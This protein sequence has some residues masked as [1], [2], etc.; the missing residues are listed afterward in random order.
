MNKYGKRWKKVAWQ[1]GLARRGKQ[2]RHNLAQST[3][4][5][6]LSVEQSP[7][8]DDHGILS[9]MLHSKSKQGIFEAVEMGQA[10][11]NIA[12]KRQ[13]LPNDLNREMTGALTP[14]IGKRKREENE[15]QASDRTQSRRSN[16]KRSSTVDEPVMSAPPH[17]LARRRQ[18]PLPNFNHSS[19]SSDSLLG[20]TISMQARTLA[21]N[22]RSDATHTD[23]FRLKA[24]GI[25]PDTP[26][27]PQTRKKAS[28][29]TRDNLRNTDDSQ[30]SKSKAAAE[31]VSVNGAATRIT[32]KSPK[33]KLDDPDEE[34]FASIKKVRDTLAD[35]TS[36]FQNERHS[37][38]RSQTSQ[39]VPQFGN[40]P[41]S[42]RETPA[43]RR[44]REIRER[45]YT[46]SRSEIRL[47]AMGDKAY[48]PEGFWDGEGMGRSLYGSDDGTSS[49]KEKEAESEDE[50][51]VDTD[52]EVRPAM[53]FA[54]LNK[55]HLGNGV[56]N[57]Q[58]PVSPDSPIQQHPPQQSGTSI[59]D[60]IEL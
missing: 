7:R 34:F 23:Y 31:T 52:D 13:S 56:V 32:P 41:P 15:E 45:G 12:K 47:R 35:S 55:Q 3:Q 39:T 42:P 40:S 53:G 19:I 57:G 46:P 5:I 22:V 44:L 18:V 37:L 11:T 60:A 29:Q 9:S 48:L 16:H 38:E 6:S 36:W 54:A 28:T 27:V 1:I 10:P 21:P 59:E 49:R 58:R 25:N 4:R 8:K 17:R 24:L 14:N 33:R 2:R 43:E 30:A 20:R 50:F 51:V 26:I